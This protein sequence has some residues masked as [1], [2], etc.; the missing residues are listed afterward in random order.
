[1]KIIL[2]SDYFRTILYLCIKTMRLTNKKALEKFKRKNKGN[3][4][5]SKTIDKLIEDI[6]GSEW[7]NQ[8]ELIQT[9]PDA[10][11][12]HS[13]GFYF[14]NIN[15]HRT[16]ILVEFDDNEASVVWVGT[17]QEYETTF[18]NNKSTIKK[19]LNSNDC[20]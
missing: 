10:N 15:I 9:R 17:H 7:E 12:V 11:C 1:M 6:E 13:D 20:I 19:W 2:S 14:F 8:T 3:V 4:L 16:M 18:K 5:L